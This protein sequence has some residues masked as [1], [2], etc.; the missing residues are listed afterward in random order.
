MRILIADDDE[1]AR[2]LLAAVLEPAGYEVIAVADGLKADAILQQPDAP[3]IAILDWRM[4]GLHGVEVARQ[5]RKRP[6]D[7]PP[8][9]ILLT[10]NTGND[11]LVA[12]LSAGANDYL[13][14]PFMSNEL[15]A[16]AAV[17]RRMIEMQNALNGKI[18]QLH[19]QA[20]FHRLAAEISADL[21]A[22]PSAAAFDQAVN[23]ALVRLARLFA[24]D[25][26]YLFRFSADLSRMRITHEWVAPGI[27]PQM[28]HVQNQPTD[29]LPWGTAQ[30]F[31]KRPIKIAD[32]SQLPPEAAAE[33]AE[34][35]RQ[36][37]RSLLCLPTIGAGGQI[38]GFMGFDMVQRVHDWPPEQIAMLQPIANAIGAA[39]ERLRAEASQQ[40][41]LTRLE[42]IAA[43]LPGV[44]YQ[45]QLFPDGRSCF[46]YASEGIAQ[47]YAVAPEEVRQDA[48]AVSERLH[49][50]DFDRV[51]A[52]IN[53]SYESGEPWRDVYRV[54]LPQQGRALAGGL[55]QP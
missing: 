16:R 22:V 2:V 4:P 12:G 37:V 47:I 28:A 25:R 27:S 13:V 11:N 38:T 41:A 15:L 5:A 36:D 30:I 35:L 29:D 18:E 44:I 31:D 8:Y 20:E 53:A 43:H 49:P 1:S 34:L 6:T 45:Y 50:E 39:V 32:V 48:T 51:I 17:G 7:N 9:I 10:G 33:K 55:R 21:A 46:P 42:R 19:F 40:E 14:K 3:Q 54:I 23:A 26:S 24:A 52:S